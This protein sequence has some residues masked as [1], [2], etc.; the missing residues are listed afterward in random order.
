MKCHVL[1]WSWICYAASVFVGL[2]LQVH[3]EFVFMYI[4]NGQLEVVGGQFF[5]IIPL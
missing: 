2:F 5:P 1:L 4:R 3:A